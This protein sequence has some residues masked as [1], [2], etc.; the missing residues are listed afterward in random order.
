MSF[1]Y[2]YAAQ[3]NNGYN[4][5]DI[6]ANITITLPGSYAMNVQLQHSIGG[7]FLK[8]DPDQEHNHFMIGLHFITSFN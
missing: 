2:G 3:N 8:Q 4:H 7:S 5:A 1:D 6:G